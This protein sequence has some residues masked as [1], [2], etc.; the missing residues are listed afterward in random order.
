V[1]DGALKS[2]IVIAYLLQSLVFF[3]GCWQRCWISKSHVF[4]IHVSPVILQKEE[5]SSR[6]RYFIFLKKY[7]LSTVLVEICKSADQIFP[8][9]VATLSELLTMR[10]SSYECFLSIGHNFC[11]CCAFYFS[12][13]EV[14]E[15]FS[16]CQIP[17]IFLLLHEPNILIL[18]I[19][20]WIRVPIVYF[21]N[22]RVVW[23]KCWITSVT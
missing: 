1:K 8:S 2:K 13:S 6:D 22:M 4:V 10:R 15:I 17:Q 21:I 23:S 3:I 7:Y 16:Q 9:I 19:V 20:R 11:L 18:G 14:L 12:P 5:V